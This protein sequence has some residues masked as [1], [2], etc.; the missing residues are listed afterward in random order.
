VSTKA[1]I[2][3]AV[4]VLVACSP[5]DSDEPY[6]EFI[7]G[8]F[9]FN[10]RLAQ[11]DYGF[12]AR[13][14]RRIPTGM[15]IEAVFENPS[16]GEPF[17]IRETAKWGR[18]QYVFRSPPVQGVKANRDYQVELRLIDPANQHVIA[19]YAKTFRSDVDQSILPER[20]TVIGPGHQPNLPEKMDQI[21]P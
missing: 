11:A 12:V 5:G 21:S 1:L 19:T 15:I 7:G 17:I 20:P 13:P 18:T 14:V 10:Y 3:T 16:G 9:I 6:F 2:I 8:G 4:V